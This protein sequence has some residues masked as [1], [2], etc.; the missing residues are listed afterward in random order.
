MDT[1]SAVL[2]HLSEVARASHNH[3]IAGLGVAGGAVSAAL[4]L[5]AMKSLWSGFK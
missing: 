1:A 2:N 5:Y 3:W 4:H